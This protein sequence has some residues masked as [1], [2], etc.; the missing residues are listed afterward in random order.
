[1]NWNVFGKAPEKSGKYLI[2]VAEYDDGILADN[3]VYMGVFDADEST[4]EWE[5]AYGDNKIPVG[6][7]DREFEGSVFST[8]VYAWAEIPAPAPL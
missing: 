5:D 4:W 3:A 1:M 8:W 7:Q 6:R 2:S